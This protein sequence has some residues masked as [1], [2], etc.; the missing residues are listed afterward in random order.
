M[1]RSLI[2]MKIPDDEVRY[3]EEAL[4]EGRSLVMV[5]VGDRYP[6][7]MDILHRVGGK[8]MAAF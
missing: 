2:G 7:A 1:F 6:E 5:Q 3:Y 4:Q 8:Y